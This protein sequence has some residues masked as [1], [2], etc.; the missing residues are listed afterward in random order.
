MEFDLPF[1]V[2]FGVILIVMI[3]IAQV[4]YAEEI[5]KKRTLRKELDKTAFSVDEFIERLRG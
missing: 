5:K 1:A 3:L 4:L 2:L